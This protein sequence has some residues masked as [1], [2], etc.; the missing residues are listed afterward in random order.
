M[1]EIN[2]RHQ[3]GG[4]NNFKLL[5]IKYMKKLLIYS[6]ALLTVLMVY[7]CEEESNMLT[8]DAVEGG[9]LTPSTTSIN[10][11]VGDNAAYGFDLYVNQGVVETQQV[12]E[13]RIYRSCYKVAVPH[14]DTEANPEDSIPAHW[15]NEELSET[16]TVTDASS[17]YESSLQMDFSF[18]R[19]GLMVQ[20]YTGADVELPTTDSK[21]NIGDKFVFR[22]ENDLKDG[23][24]IE[25]AY[26][27]SL[28]VS[29]R[30]AGKYKLVE[31]LYYRLGVLSDQGSYWP[32]ETLIESVDAKTYKM[33]GLAAWIDNELYFQIEDDGSITYPA[34]WNGTAQILNDQPLITCELNPGDLSNVSCENYVVKD[35]ETGKDQLIMTFGYYTTGSGPREFYQKM[36]KIVD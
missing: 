13:I 25:Q 11:V 35:D 12:S 32:E 28:A 16:I 4:L 7:S 31:G 24:T 9:L 22:I 30:F 27:I 34:E 33:I 23:R 21:M 6:F 17:H 36:E 8:E 20:D 5:M 19:E 14:S 29:T 3:C 18:L 2:Y 26:D 1:V 10:Y 15:S